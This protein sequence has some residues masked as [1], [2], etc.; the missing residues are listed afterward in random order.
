MPRYSKL[1]NFA[2]TKGAKDKRPRKRRSGL[3]DNEYKGARTMELRTRS[4]SNLGRVL[5]SVSNSVREARLT[6]KW[7]GINPSRKRSDPMSIVRNAR[8]VSDTGNSI[9][10]LGRGLFGMR[11]LN[12]MMAEFRRG[13]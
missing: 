1:A 7:L 9:L 10:R 8:S 12:S 6:A 11:S 4:I 2:R 3:L 13:K 5:N